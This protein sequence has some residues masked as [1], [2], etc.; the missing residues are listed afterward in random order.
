MYWLLLT[1]LLIVLIKTKFLEGTEVPQ[2][3]KLYNTISNKLPTISAH[4]ESLFSVSL[5][6]WTCLVV[7]FLWWLVLVHLLWVLIVAGTPYQRDAVSCHWIACLIHC[8]SLGTSVA[9]VTAGNR[10]LATRRSPVWARTLPIGRGGRG[11]RERWSLRAT[12]ISPLLRE[13]TGIG[14]GRGERDPLRL[15]T[16]LVLS[17]V[18]PSVSLCS[19]LNLVWV[20]LG[21]GS[22]LMYRVSGWM[23]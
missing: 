17:Q 4:A 15:V 6:V 23:L 11:E 12:G 13:D 5:F 10:C 19:S 8:P 22:V 7:L 18:R 9:I 21:V 2:K 1:T 20:W 3:E 14:R 16:L